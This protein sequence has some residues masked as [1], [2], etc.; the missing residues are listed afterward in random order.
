MA[1]GGG[2][3]QFLVRNVEENAV[4]VIAGFLGADRKA[5]AVDQLG[6]RGCGQFEAGRQVAFDDHREIV[7]RQGRQ[8]EAA[9]PGLHRHAVVRR[10]QADL[11]AIGQFAGNIEQQVRRYGDRS[12]AF[13]RDCAQA[14]H[15]L[16]VK[17]G[18]HDPHR[19][20]ARCFDQHV[21]QDRNGIAPLDDGLDVRQALQERRA[22]DSGLHGTIVSP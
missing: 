5:G 10:F 11:A 18:R 6:Q 19:A 3:A 22:F 20:V 4:Q 15:D 21:R 13:D 9:A 12:G 1:I 8:A 16:Q 14:F 2:G 7:T 17:V